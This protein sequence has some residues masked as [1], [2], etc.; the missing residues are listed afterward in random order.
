VVH[1]VAAAL[2][3]CAGYESE[4][5]RRANSGCGRKVTAAGAGVASG[6]GVS[7]LTSLPVLR[8]YQRLALDAFEADRV[9]GRRRT[10][11]VAPPGSGKTVIGVEMV[12]RLGAPALVLCPTAAIRD[13]W[14]AHD[15]GVPLTAL[16]YQAICQT[17]DPEGAL[18]TAAEARWEG[19]QR[20]SGPGAGARSRR[21]E[22]E[23]RAIV[24]AIKREAARG[25][26]AAALLSANARARARGLREAGVRT[27]VLDEC[28][29]LVSLW[30]YL[31]REALA[32]LGPEVHVIGLTA[33]SPD[34]MTEEEAALYRE[35]LGDVDFETPT[36][37]VVRDGYL[38]PYQ[39]LA[40]FT[41]PLKSELDWLA[42]RHLRFQEMLDRLMEVS[43]DDLSFTLWVSNRMRHRGS[44]EAEVS[45]AEVLRRQPELARAGL[46]YL[47]GA[48]LPAPPGA[49]RGEGFREPPTM[50]DW[51]VLIS[52][53]ALRCLRA[54]PENQEE[55]DRRLDELAVG[56]ADLGFT[57]T[58]TGVRPGRTDI[59][60]VLVHSSAKGI[61]ACEAL[62]CELDGRAGDLRAVVLCDSERPP[63]RPEGTPLELGG[64]GRG[65]VAVIA[66]DARLALTR[67]LLVTGETFACAREDA[68]AL[69]EELRERKVALGAL[70]EL[71][72]LTMVEGLT[73]R[74]A[75]A[76]SLLRDGWTRCVV[77]T[78]ALLGEGWD[79]PA[80]NCLVDVTS[81][82]ASIST[83][84]MRGRSL[85]LDPQNPEKTASNW[86][87]VC[88][89]PNL[90]RGVADYGRFVRRHT[91]LLA[92]CEDGS[93]ESGVSHVHPRLNPYAPPR[94]DEFAALN[95][96]ALARARDPAGARERW[97]IGDPYRAVELPA[98][99]V[100]AI[101][102][103]E[104]PRVA[105]DLS[106]LQ[107][108]GP[109]RWWLLPRRR[110]TRFSAVLPL[111]RVARAVAD[112]LLALGMLEEDSAASLAWQPRAEGWARCLLPA[113]SP[114]ENAR[115]T[116]ALDDAIAP[117]NGQRYVVSRPVG[118][119]ARWPRYG[120]AWHPVPN[121]LGRNHERAD[122]YHAAFARW[123]GPSELR[124][125][126]SSKDG[127]AALAE[128]SAAP[129]KY[130]TQSR[131]LWV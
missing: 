117:A 87:I 80:V 119:D 101:G 81:V 38:A 13:Q 37:A 24:A 52:D 92:P 36:P 46:R 99:L 15:P 48:G 124:Y 95:A 84:Q 8:P 9:A 19:E 1:I 114:E 68:E 107:P 43:E 110:R 83:R 98:L 66:A 5:V 22:R 16:T 33:T 40:L 104:L 45:F 65:L 4:G 57:L 70:R 73:E 109:P 108:P 130:E 75:L 59:D 105:V 126:R 103:R 106:G 120:V 64:G 94:A 89:A 10:Y 44:G 42:E 14:E 71:D 93:I 55:A 31:V 72:G 100:R 6:L 39:E 61:L 82:A 34:E 78:R 113:G 60:R 125:A 25:G 63:K 128:A 28:H 96:A 123:L 20:A 69:T 127:R 112:A 116:A 77:G 53:Y 12:R 18:R 91:H 56:L 118:G 115:F 54:Q 51:I 30:G 3:F 85:R 121:E 131:R 76:S 79:A 2:L 58:R 67:P 11:V 41:T 50:E 26:E 102:S 49:P 97:R 7:V 90:E 21:R 29:H 74:V 35:L 47:H 32:I 27:V 86:D 23:L 17:E 88:V 62:A 122:V 129:E 111:E